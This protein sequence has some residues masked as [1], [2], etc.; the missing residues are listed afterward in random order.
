MIKK[1][2]SSTA[3]PIA[4]C[5]RVQLSYRQIYE[6]EPFFPNFGIS[7]N[8]LTG[9]VVALGSFD[10]YRTCWIDPPITIGTAA[11]AWDRRLQHE[12]Q[13]VAAVVAVVI[14]GSFSG[15]K[16]RDICD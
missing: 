13:V 15:R 6:T 11:A 16:R 7:F 4:Q 12:G 14:A 9:I 3:I 5:F 10:L 8:S 2:I 1:Q